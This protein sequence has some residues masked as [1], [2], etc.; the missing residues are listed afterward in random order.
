MKK[1][2]IMQVIQFFSPKMGG[3]VG[4]VYGLSK[5]LAKMGHEVTICTSDYAF[6][7]E[8]AKELPGVRIEKFASKFGKFIYTP[9]MKNWLLENIDKYDILHLN[10]YWGYQN[11]VASDVAIK[12]NVPYVISPHGSIPV[13][14][15]SYL[16][17]LVFDVKY[18]RMI[19]KNAQ[20]AIATSEMEKKQIE[21]K[22]I[23]SHRIEVIPNGIFLPPVSKDD[24]T[25][26]RKKYG[27]G[28][29]DKVI[30]YLGRI[31]KGKGVDILLLAFSEI[32]KTF[33]NARLVIVGPDDGYLNNIKKIIKDKLLQKKVVITGPLY[34]DDKYRAYK[35]ADIY[36]LNS[37][38]EIFGNTILEACGC[39]VPV[40]INDQCGISS[41]IKDKCG[42]TVKYDKDDLADAIAKL[43]L[44]DE[45]RREFSKNGEEM[46][47]RSFTWEVIA[48]RY[49]SLYYNVC[50]NRG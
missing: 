37:S 36:V 1:L 25:V 41:V 11:I 21:S 47:K 22:G 18:G 9:K 3:S 28:S 43:L 44:S 49:E 2:K 31:H 33:N 10:N 42:L 13:I 16:R 24:L 35:A 34:G 30:L 40:I 50:Q 17:K 12:M 5:T 29:C 7:N 27:L 46:V 4:N 15:N 48:K 19:L 23:S 8:Y 20:M 14:I 32:L 6:D 26:F 38:Y 39:G 45:L